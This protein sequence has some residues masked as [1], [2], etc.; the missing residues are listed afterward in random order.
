MLINPV[1]GQSVCVDYVAL[2]NHRAD[3]TL[4]NWRPVDSLI[5]YVTPVD[6]S[7]FKVIVKGGRAARVVNDGCQRL[8]AVKWEAPNVRPVGEKQSRSSVCCPAASR[9][10]W[11]SSVALEALALESSL[12]VDA[13]LRADARLQTLVHVCVVIVDYK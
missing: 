3:V 8:V 11:V 4:V 9:I 7:R 5:I 12:L 10:M 13:S 2:N 1:D 6:Y